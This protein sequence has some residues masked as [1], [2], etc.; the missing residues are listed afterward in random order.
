MYNRYFMF[1][2]EHLNQIKEVEKKSG[3]RNYSCGKV[4]VNGYFKP[5]TSIVRSPEEYSRY[6]DAKIV[7]SGDIRKAKY[8]DAT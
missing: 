2:Q 8:K 5:F 4:L 1:S 3:N 6:S 7:F